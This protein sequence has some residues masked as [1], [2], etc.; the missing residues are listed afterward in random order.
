MF[1]VFICEF[2]CEAKKNSHVP[3]R[4]ISP[5]FKQRF[6]LA[7]FNRHKKDRANAI[8]EA[9]EEISDLRCQL[10][11]KAG[12]LEDLK[13]KSSQNRRTNSKEKAKGLLYC[14]IKM[15]S[16]IKCL[17]NQLLNCNF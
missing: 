3:F 13:I 12:E 9:S 5:S 2:C 11:D 4:V 1:Y 10:D 8:I 15:I 6:P 7:A 17:N 14:H 16:L